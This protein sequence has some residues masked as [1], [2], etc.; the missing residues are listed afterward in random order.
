MLDWDDFLTAAKELSPSALKL[1]MYLAKNQDGYES[2]L[3]PKDFCMNFDVKDRTYREAKAML[4]QKGYMKEEKNNSIV[5]NTKPVFKETTETLKKY[6]IELSNKI[7]L[8]DE[9]CY[10]QLK[11]KTCN[12]QL[13]KIKNENIYK[14]EIKKLIEEAERMLKQLSTYEMSKLI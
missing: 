4:E 11:E 9:N 14:I 8:K 10:L 7:E 5:F 12:A 2:Y 1:Y 6:L 3:S 13:P